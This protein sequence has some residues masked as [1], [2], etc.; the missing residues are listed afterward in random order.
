MN[1]YN[2][3]SVVVLFLTVVFV[4]GCAPEGATRPTVGNVGDEVE[5]KSEEKV[6]VAEPAEE[7][8]EEVAEK[9]ETPDGVRWNVQIRGLALVPRI[10]TISAGDTVVWHNDDEQRGKPVEHM[11]ATHQDLFR[12][13]R[14]AKGETFTYVFN[15]TGTFTYF[16]VIFKTRDFLRGTINVQ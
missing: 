2:W 12:S 6:E 8:K 11:L 13:E 5:E 10:I 4:L 16:D 1:R 15:E 14:F 7:V 9:V 3:F